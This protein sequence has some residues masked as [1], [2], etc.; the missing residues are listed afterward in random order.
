[1]DEKW[2]KS[3]RRV[4]NTGIKVRKKWEKK[5]RKVREKQEKCKR[6]VREKLE[7]KKVREE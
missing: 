7:K 3:N 4:G 2:E 1:M 5:E 6:K